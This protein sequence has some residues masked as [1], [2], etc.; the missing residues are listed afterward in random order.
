MKNV[1]LTLATLTAVSGLLL[2]GV[3]CAPPEAKPSASSSAGAATTKSAADVGGM[4]GLVTAA[5]AEGALNVIAL[6]PN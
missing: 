1:R 3:G 4:E 2:A 6:P 5:K